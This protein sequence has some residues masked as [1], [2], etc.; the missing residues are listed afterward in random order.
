[1]TPPLRRATMPGR[2]RKGHVGE[3]ADV[4]VDDPKLIL[5]GQEVA[6]PRSP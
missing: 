3:R 6:A 5:G 4:D 1:M 2:K